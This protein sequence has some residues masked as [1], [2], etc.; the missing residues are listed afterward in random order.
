MPLKIVFL[1]APKLVSIKTLLLKHYYRRQGSRTALTVSWF[2][3]LPRSKRFERKRKGGFAK[4]LFWQ[5][6]PRF[7]LWVWGPG[8]SK[9][10]NHIAFFC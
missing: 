1:E 2:S 9:I 3:F 6:R 5:M 10:R 8:M 4:G 7:G